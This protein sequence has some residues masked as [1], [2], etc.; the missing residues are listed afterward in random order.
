MTLLQ[1]I[2]EIENGFAA[3]NPFINRFGN[4]PF[5]TINENIPNDGKYPILWMIP[6]GVRIDD[7]SIV[8]KIRFLIFDKDDTDDS[9][10]NQKLNDT[11]GTIIDLWKFIKIDS[12][13]LDD[14]ELT[15]S[16]QAIPFEQK[17]V[18]YCVGWYMDLELATDGQNNPCNIL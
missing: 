11:L 9:L 17:F 6:Q 1:I 14:I 16:A 15:G 13:E 5:D 4:G 7:N 8:Y 3:N 10:R 12:A 18:D 2:N